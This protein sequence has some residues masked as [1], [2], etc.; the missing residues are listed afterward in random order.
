M[1]GE[2]LWLVGEALE[3]EPSDGWEFVRW[4]FVGIYLWKKEALAACSG[5][6]FFYVQVVLGETAPQGSTEWP[7]V[8]YPHAA[9]VSE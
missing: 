5:D 8:V 9:E 7:G 2:Y 1:T 3:K 6:L 4:E